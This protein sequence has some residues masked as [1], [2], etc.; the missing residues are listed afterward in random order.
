MR[1]NSPSRVGVYTRKGPKEVKKHVL[2][3][4]HTTHTAIPAVHS[5]WS[6][7]PELLLSFMD[8]AD[9]VDESLTSFWHSLLWPVSELELPDGPRLTVLQDTQ[10]YRHTQCK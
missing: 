6:V 8:L 2:T 7:L 3:L 5:D 4:T 1:T 10:S 9:E